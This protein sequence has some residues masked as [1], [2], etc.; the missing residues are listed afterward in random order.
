MNL[1]FVSKQISEY[2]RVLLNA[3][4]RSLIYDFPKGY[5]YDRCKREVGVLY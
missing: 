1:K 3:G 4:I 5:T 2:N